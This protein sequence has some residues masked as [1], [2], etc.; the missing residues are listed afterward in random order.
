MPHPD[1]LAH[2]IMSVGRNKA[3]EKAKPILKGLSFDCIAVRGTS[4]L[5]FGAALAYELDK[6][7]AVIRKT[8]RGCNSQ[9]WVESPDTVK[10]FLVVDDLIDS[11]A[12]IRAILKRMKKEHPDAECIGAYLSYES[13]LL[14]VDRLKVR[15]KH[16]E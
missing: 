16:Y 15:I 10:K 2:G 4:G 1:Y 12:T 7:V 13:E 3:V 14:S 5:G 8:R 9:N 6:N 11:G